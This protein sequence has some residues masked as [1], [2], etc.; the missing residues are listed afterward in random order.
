[1]HIGIFGTLPVLQPLERMWWQ[2]FEPLL[3]KGLHWFDTAPLWQIGL[4]ALVIA[5]VISTAIRRRIAENANNPVWVRIGGKVF[6]ERHFF[7]HWFITGYTGC[8]KTEGGINRLMFEVFK[9]VPRW[10][11]CV[12]DEKGVA[13]QDLSAFASHAGRLDDVI[14]LKSRPHDAPADWQPAWTWNP[15]LDMRF[16]DTSHAEM[17]IRTANSVRK[18]ESKDPFW[19]PTATTHIARL[20]TALRLQS[21]YPVSI[22]TV[23][24][25]LT[26]QSAGRLRDLIS[27]LRSQADPQ[28]QEIADHFAYRFI[29]LE[30]RLLDNIRGT[31]AAYLSA[32]CEPALREIFCGSTSTFTV[33][34]VDSGKIVCFSISPMFKTARTL[35]SALL[36]NM[37]CE[38]ANLRFSLPKAEL[39]KAMPLILWM[40]EAQLL[41]SADS[42]KGDHTYAS[43]LR[44]AR[45]AFVMATQDPVISFIPVLGRDI[46]AA[47]K[48]NL[49][50]QIH[51]QAA[52]EE[53][54]EWIANLIGKREVR[55]VNT[56]VGPTGTT[57]SRG[58]LTQQRFWIEPSVIRGM[59]AFRALIRH[60]EGSSTKRPV[61]LRPVTPDGKIPSWYQ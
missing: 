33:D 60:C 23:V 15:L 38:H 3:Q 12:L 40:D 28:A 4:V 25:L 2:T 19:E 49:G 50:N 45:L 10:G 24:D 27:V 13:H 47:L 57:R 30:Q 8:G 46:A 20:I 9:N 58:Q 34:A 53:A 37:I 7:R 51:L 29:S 1:M 41:V 35:Y 21:H 61:T 55:D 11:G 17:L 16:P 32:F 56:S 43:I 26:E 52:S 48:L 42:Q 44:Q 39:D 5:A 14:V 6:R 59:K 54:A 31:I 36:K 22:A 18:A